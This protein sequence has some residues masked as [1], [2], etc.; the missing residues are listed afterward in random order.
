MTM[1]GK[2]GKLDS[3][4]ARTMAGA[5]TMKEKKAGGEKFPEFILPKLDHLERKL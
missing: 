2:N 5:Q 4:A 1:H 3:Q